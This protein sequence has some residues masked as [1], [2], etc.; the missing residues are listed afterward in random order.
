M[1]VVLVPNSN[2]QSDCAVLSKH[3]F[4]A[5]VKLSCSLHRTSDSKTGCR[6]V[7]LD[8]KTRAVLEQLS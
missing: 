2:E 1:V 4:P 8:S 5:C 6:E 7:M 3:T